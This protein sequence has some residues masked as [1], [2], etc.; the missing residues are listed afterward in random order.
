MDSAALAVCGVR[1][2]ACGGAARE[3]ALGGWVVGWCPSSGGVFF[4]GLLLVRCRLGFVGLLLALRVCCLWVCVLLRVFY[5][6]I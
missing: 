3:I 1:R 4:V 6:Y 5:V 2:A